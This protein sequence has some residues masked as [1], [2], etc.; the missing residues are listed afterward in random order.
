MTSK[1][2]LNKVLNDM[3][4]VVVS[5]KGKGK[6]GGGGGGG[7]RGGGGGGGGKTIGLWWW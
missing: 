2:C 1:Y 3:L 4:T 7:K 5:V 6:L